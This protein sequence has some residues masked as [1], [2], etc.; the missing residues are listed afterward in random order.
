MQMKRRFT[1]KTILFRISLVGTIA[2]AAFHAQ[3]LSSLDG[4]ASAKSAAPAPARYSVASLGA[5][6]GTFSIAFGVNNAGRIGG[7][8]ALP[9]GDT[10]AFLSGIGTTKYDIGT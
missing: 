4:S 5:L 9:N 3:S 6:G 1:M 7:A 8:A 2:A 10:H